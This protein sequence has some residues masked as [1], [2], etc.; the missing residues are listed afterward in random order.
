MLEDLDLHFVPATVLLGPK[1]TD[2]K[3]DPVE[4]YPRNVGEA[5]GQRLGVRQ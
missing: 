1:I 2:A 3:T 4:G 5:V